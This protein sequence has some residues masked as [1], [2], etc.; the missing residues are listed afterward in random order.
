MQPTEVICADVKV[1]NPLKKNFLG[2]Q[3]DAERGAKVAFANSFEEKSAEVLGRPERIVPPGNVNGQFSRVNGTGHVK[4]KK[5]QYWHAQSIGN[6]V[7]CV[8]FESTCGGWSPG[9]VAFMG[10]L[11]EQHFNDA[12]HAGNKGFSSSAPTF[13]QHHARCVSCALSTRG[14]RSR[15]EIPSKIHTVLSS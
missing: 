5:A 2:C 11:A 7:H 14:W 10:V 15:H 3:R 13:T 1:T 12:P 8:H 9:A 4:A 6:P